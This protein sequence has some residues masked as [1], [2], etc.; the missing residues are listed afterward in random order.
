MYPFHLSKPTYAVVEHTAGP[1]AYRAVNNKA[2]GV[3]TKGQEAYHY[4]L[5]A[6]R[7]KTAGYKGGY[8][9]APVTIADKIFD[10]GIHR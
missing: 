2:P 9:H 8:Q 5:A 3:K 10:E 7:E 1:V 4:G 6:E